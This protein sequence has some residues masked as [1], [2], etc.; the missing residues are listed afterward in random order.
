MAA[1]FVPYA[2]TLYKA[3]SLDLKKAGALGVFLALAAGVGFVGVA[4]LLSDD[5]YRILWEGR[6][7]AEGFS[8]YV[9]SPDSVLL[10][11][12]RDDAW[13]RINHRHLT[14]IYPPLAQT[15]SAVAHV[16][17]GKVWSVQLVGLVLLVLCTWAVA[18]VAPVNR[19]RAA[20]ALALNP[21]VVVESVH[22][23]HLDLLV[24]LL[25]CLLCLAVA[26][27]Q[28]LRACA[29]VGAVAAAKLIGWVFIPLLRDRRWAMVVAVVLCTAAV[30]P[31]V[32]HSGPTEYA[33]TWRG[34]ESLYA[35]MEAGCAWIVEALFA[36]DGRVELASL[37][38]MPRQIAAP[39]VRFVVAGAV[40]GIVATMTR[41]RYS[42]IQT[43]KIAVVAVLL[44][45]PQ[46]HPWYLLWLIPVDL[47][48]G[49][50]VGLAWSAAVLTAYLPIEGWLA[51]RVWD[52]SIWVRG[53]QYSVVASALWVDM[54][55]LARYEPTQGNTA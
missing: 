47:C 10:A 51:F 6:V 54:H 40:F 49:G 24:G 36:R 9:V 38:L 31:L 53:F 34:N 2:W 13:T 52:E 35:I 46:V 33:L 19:T 45:S 43:V 20:V 44:L 50:I 8:P 41:K 25:L 11:H 5:V 4:P 48:A 12:L 15:L 39:M 3:P 29:L 22:S 26:N 23:A 14:T 30:V 16:L 1:S 21:L 37:T 42:T 27:K 28:W 32:G 18:V 7:V 55:R 17:G